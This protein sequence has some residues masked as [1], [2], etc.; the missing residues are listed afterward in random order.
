VL[1]NTQQFDHV[2]F[3]QVLNLR[4]KALFCRHS[5]LPAL[6]VPYLRRR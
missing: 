4:L 3:A 2:V 1:D 5:R 6:V